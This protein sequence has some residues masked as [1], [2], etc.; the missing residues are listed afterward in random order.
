M[1]RRFHGV[2]EQRPLERA[3]GLRRIG[4]PFQQVRLFH[5]RPVVIFV[6]GG[7]L[8]ELVRGRPKESLLLLDL[9]EQPVRAVLGRVLR[10]ERLGALQVRY[11]AVQ[12]PVFKQCSSGRELRDKVAGIRP[13][14]LLQ[15]LSG[16]SFARARRRA[17]P[18]G[19]DGAVEALLEKGVEAQA[20]D[21]R[22][23]AHPGRGQQAADPGEI[24]REAAV[25]DDHP[26]RAPRRAGGVHHVGEA[27]GPR[28]PFGSR[29][30]LRRG[31]LDAVERQHLDR[32]EQR[33]R[34]D[35]APLGD[36]PS[37]TGVGGQ[38]GQPRGRL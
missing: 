27:L 32:R 9:G 6:H 11:R 23:R 24:A 33:Q 7:E 5:I 22:Q 20:G 19:G 34:R 28:E 14:P 29:W 37:E 8:R 25:L 35:R 36:R 10:K 18:K 21:R 1:Y 13:G 3:G 2:D 38:P 4:E 12:L 15:L 26:L 17:R 30:R 31:L 16:V